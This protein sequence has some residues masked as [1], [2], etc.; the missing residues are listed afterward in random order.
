M[1]VNDEKKMERINSV[2]IWQKGIEK[3]KKKKKTY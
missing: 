3:E 1:L 2:E